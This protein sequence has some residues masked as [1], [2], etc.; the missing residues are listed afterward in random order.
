[1]RKHVFAG[2]RTFLDSSRV[3]RAKARVEVDIL[4]R[5]HR[6]RYMVVYAPRGSVVLSA[7][8]VTVDGKIEGETET[9]IDEYVG[10]P[11]LKITDATVEELDN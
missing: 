2:S 4:K 9:R 8:E 11:A 3:S 5:L 10:S 7:S 6:I 1:M